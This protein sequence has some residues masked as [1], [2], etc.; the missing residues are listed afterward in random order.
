MMRSIYTTLVRSLLCFF[1]VRQNVWSLLV[2]DDTSRPVALRRT[3]LDFSRDQ[4][5]VAGATSETYLLSNVLGRWIGGLASAWMDLMRERRLK[6]RLAPLGRDAPVVELLECSS[7]GK[8]VVITRLLKKEGRRPFSA[9]QHGGVVSA[10]NASIHEKVATMSSAWSNGVPA[11]KGLHAFVDRYV[12]FFRRD[13]DTDGVKRDLALAIAFAMG[14][15]DDDP[16]LVFSLIAQ[17]HRTDRLVLAQIMGSTF[18]D[19]TV[20]ADEHILTR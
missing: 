13:D 12:G 18:R 5:G 2:G 15:M 4:D 20:G 3:V 7:H 19:V 9:S 10:S 1:R 14:Y 11:P 17:P 16:R 6:R 8:I